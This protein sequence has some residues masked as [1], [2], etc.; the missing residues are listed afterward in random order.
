MN[1]SK[2]DSVARLAYTV[3]MVARITILATSQLPSESEFRFPDL[4]DKAASASLFT[5]T[6]YKPILYKQYILFHFFTLKLTFVKSFKLKNSP[7]LVLTFVYINIYIGLF[8]LGLI[9]CWISQAKITPFP[10]QTFPLNFHPCL[11][12]INNK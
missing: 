9:I 12:I 4:T 11:L 10:I 5:C 6:L 2:C 7:K 1:T 8:K 3:E